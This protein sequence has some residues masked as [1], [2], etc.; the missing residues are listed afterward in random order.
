MPSPE[1]GTRP[2]EAADWRTAAR[3]A[4]EALGAGHA[5]A[6]SRL[7]AIE[8][9]GIAWPA[10]ASVLILRNFTVEPL[11]RYLKLAAYR[12]G[13]EVEVELAGYDTV[14]FDL[15]DPS[16]ALRSSAHDV[17][18]LALWLEEIR[19]AYDSGGCL[20]V[21]AAGDHVTALV[22]GLLGAINA[23]V[24]INTFLP[25]F[26]APGP[27]DADIVRLNRRVHA[28]AEGRGRVLVSDL[29]AKSL[30]IGRASSVDARFWLSARAPV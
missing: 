24:L 19:E 13:I 10:C 28:L 7:G 9:A 5:A 22:E 23:T 15:R 27:T 11:D 2:A 14:A 25:A 21:D 4:Q 29:H 20:D 18:V 26:G 6:L 8:R 1:L 12:R 16:S 3:D 30:E 17:V